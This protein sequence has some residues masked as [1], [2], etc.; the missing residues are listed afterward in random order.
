MK[1]KIFCVYDCK[2]EAFLTPFFM[3]TKGEALRAWG[4]T[5]NDPS[6]NF[7]KYPG[8]Y[9]LFELADFDSL[10]AAIVPHSAKVSLGTALEHKAPANVAPITKGTGV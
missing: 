4:T 9:T 7:F 5:V 3:S 10:T 2:V 8:D 1:L 6:T